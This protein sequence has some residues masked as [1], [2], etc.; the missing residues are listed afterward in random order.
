MRTRRSSPPSMTMISR[1]RG[2]VA[3]QR[4]GGVQL[5]SSGKLNRRSGVQNQTNQRQINHGLLFFF[6]LQ[7]PSLV[8]CVRRLPQVYA[9]RLLWRRRARCLCVRTCPPLD[10]DDDDP[11]LA[12]GLPVH[13]LW[14]L[15]ILASAATDWYNSSNR[16]QNAGL[17]TDDVN[18][19]V[20]P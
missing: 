14:S 1:I 10:D 19:S 5:R 6:F 12:A 9:R 17:R 20:G 18:G 4:K 3:R 7:S 11:T 15:S 16:T 13:Q 8:Y 2:E